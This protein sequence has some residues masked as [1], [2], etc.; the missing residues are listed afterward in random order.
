MR[1]LALLLAASCGT[2]AAAA[3]AEPDALRVTRGEVAER[4]LL[5]GQLVAERAERSIVPMTRIWQLSIRWLAED[6]AAAA[7]GDRV[8][9][10]DNSVFVGELAEKR[11]RLKQA[12]L[13]L[14][15]Q[16]ATAA[17]ATADKQFA[18][19]REKILLEKAE[20]QAALPKEFQPERDWQEK[21]LARERAQV[22]AR[23]AEAELA[24]QTRSAALE[25]RVKE[26]EADKIRRDLEVAEKGIAA[27][28]LTA[29]RAGILLVGEHPW[30]GRKF[31]VGDVVQPGWTVVELPDLSTMRVEA[32]LSDVDDGRVAVGARATSTLDA[33]PD[34]PLSGTVRE[35]APV[36]QEVGQQSLRRAFKVVIALDRTDAE[37]MRP[38]MSVKVEVRG[39]ATSG[40]TAPRAA[41]DIAGPAAVLAGGERVP[42][43]LGACDA[44]RCLVTKGLAEG[45]PLARRP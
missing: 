6:G 27:L 18:L 23:K 13:D 25:I 7:A 26:I 8:V 1:R 9:E 16:R 37:K 12:L 4:V 38:G 42:I 43:E 45:Q 34:Q 35:V 40:L 33:Y 2:G 11:L 36:A 30:E 21:Q 39:A 10:F 28:T 3:P 32:T 31:Q 5:T 19:A 44:Q 14:A 17:A 22:A 24:A 20:L 15:A 29:P 41:L